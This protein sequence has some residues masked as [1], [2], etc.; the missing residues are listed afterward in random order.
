MKTWLKENK[1][2]IVGY[3]I[4]ILAIIILYLMFIYLPSKMTPI[5]AT[6][7]EPELNEV[8]RSIYP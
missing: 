8:G 3:G 2:K 4:L 7:Y 5:D 1:S 6:N